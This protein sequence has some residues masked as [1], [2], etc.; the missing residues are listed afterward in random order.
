MPNRKTQ[1]LLRETSHDYLKGKNISPPFASSKN[2][3]PYLDA[4]R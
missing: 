2:I 1:K 3:D 4:L